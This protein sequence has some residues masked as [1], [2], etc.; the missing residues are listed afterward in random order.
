MKMPL[1][2][3]TLPLWQNNCLH[4]INLHF[5]PWLTLKH[6]CSWYLCI[7]PFIDILFAE[8]QLHWDPGYPKV[9]FC[10][11][12]FVSLCYV[13]VFYPLLTRISDYLTYSNRV[14]I[15]PMYFISFNSSFTFFLIKKWMQKSF[16]KMLCCC[17]FCGF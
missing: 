14:P 12:W 13:H 10:L 1:W 8:V 4:I 7:R 16:K 2:K 5:L 6:I 17:P 15:S 3:W 9:Y 11:Q